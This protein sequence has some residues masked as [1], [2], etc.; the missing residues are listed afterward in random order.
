MTRL[1]NTVHRKRFDRVP[2]LDDPELP[3]DVARN[4]DRAAIVLRLRTAA[5]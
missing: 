5:A 3:A 4:R 2:G 1:R